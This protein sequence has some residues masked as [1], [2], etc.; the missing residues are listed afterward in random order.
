VSPEKRR[1]ENSASP[2]RA[3]ILRAAERTFAEAGL[4][5]A[6]VDQIAARAGVNKALLYYYFRSKEGLYRAV[7]EAQ[8]RAFAEQAEKVFAAPGDAPSK[9][10]GFVSAHFDFLSARPLLPSLMQRFFMTGGHSFDRLRATYVLPTYRGLIRIIEKGVE[11]GE[12]YE[13]DGRQT[14]LSLAALVVHYFLAAP[15]LKTMARMDAYDRA[16]LSL[17]KREV[18]GFVRRAL[19]RKEH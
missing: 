19:V 17:R 13:V 2:S 16:N 5:G 6:R 18:L 14:A 9:V 15:W 3:S 4:S 1:R 8:L 7:L 12:F 11:D 10:L